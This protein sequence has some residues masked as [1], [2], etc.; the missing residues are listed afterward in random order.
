[1]ETRDWLA[2]MS[3]GVQR[4]LHGRPL[5]EQRILP[6]MN[7]FDVP[8]NSLRTVPFGERVARWQPWSGIEREAFDAL[9]AVENRSF[10][11]DW[12]G[13]WL[14]ELNPAAEEFRQIL[15]RAIGEPLP[16]RHAA[17]QGIF[18]TAG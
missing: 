11:R 4:L 16:T 8:G 2:T 15:E 13:A 5:F 12:Y 14:G 3:P 6:L 9:L 7:V 1:M 17:G 10:L 18:S